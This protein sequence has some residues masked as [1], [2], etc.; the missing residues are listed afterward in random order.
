MIVEVEQ[1]PLFF[2]IF[3]VAGGMVEIVESGGVIRKRR[4]GLGAFIA[5]DRGFDVAAG[6][7]RFAETGIGLVV[8]GEGFDSCGV[9]FFGFRGAA[10]LH[11]GDGPAR[12]CTRRCFRGEGCRTDGALHDVDGSGHV[13]GQ[14]V[15]PGG[16][17]VTGE[18]GPEGHH[19]L[20]GFGGG[21]ILAEL[22]QGIAESAPIPGIGRSH[23][24]EAARVLGDAGEFVPL[25]LDFAAQ[26]EACNPA[27]RRRRRC[28]RFW[29]RGRDS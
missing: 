15:E 26:A 5:R 29:T 23:L 7:L 25:Q 16:A 8:T 28:R 12:R 3:L 1:I 9:D 13:A 6:G 20:I 4:G 22:N 18:I 27:N 21:V 24:G 11:A 17:I 10:G 2:G 19:F 14:E